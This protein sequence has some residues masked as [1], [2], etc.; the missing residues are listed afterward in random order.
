MTPTRRCR[1]PDD[2]GMVTVEAAITIF[3]LVLTLSLGAATV[4]AVMTQLRCTDAA[5]EAAR[6]VARGEPERADALAHAIAPKDAHLTVRLDGDSIEVEVSS[7]SP[8]PGLHL[9]ARAYA[10]LEPTAP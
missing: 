10:V 3:A 9:T 4:I 1:S 6:L 7:D 5:R 2:S 8:L